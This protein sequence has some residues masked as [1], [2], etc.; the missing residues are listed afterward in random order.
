AYT[1]TSRPDGHYMKLSV[2]DHDGTELASAEKK[3]AWVIG[4]GRHSRSYVADDGDG[5]YQMPVCWYPDKPRWDLCPGYDTNRQQF[6]R[7]IEASCLFCHNA[8]VGLVRGSENRYVEPMP[9][10]IDCERCH[11]PGEL[12]VARWKHLSDSPPSGDDT[13]VNPRKLPRVTRI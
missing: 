5:L 6:G 8:R 12:H 1:M 9:H 13:I 3:I 11:G 2:L 10:G 4:S 7:K